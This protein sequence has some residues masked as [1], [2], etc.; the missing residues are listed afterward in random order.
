MKRD[1]YN[2]LCAWKQSSS[3]KPLILK[4]ARQVGKTY[5]LQEFGAKEYDSVAYYNFEEDPDLKDIFT[6]RMSP[7]K[8]ID[9]L[10]IYQESRITPDNT[11]II[12][13]EVQN[14]PQT[15]T[16]LKYFCEN[17]PEY[18]IAAAGSLLGVKVGQTAPFP[19][20]KV[21]FLDMHPMAFGEFLDALGKEQLRKYIQEK[22]DFNSI[23]Q[24]FHAEL[25]DFLKIYYFVGG[26]P[27]AVGQ[28][29]Q[30]KDLNT[31]RKIQ[32]EILAAYEMDFSKYTTKAEAIR[33]SGIWASIPGQ[34]S[35]EN[36]KFILS[37]VDKNARAREY[38]ES[39]QWLMD[40]GLVKKAN[41]IKIPKLPLSGYLDDKFKIYLLD[42]GLLGAM[43]N[44]SQKAIIEGD[45]LFSEYNGA[46][47]ENYVAQEFAAQGEKELY[48]WASRHTAEIDFIAAVKDE[49]L[50]LEVKSGTSRQKKSL[51]VYGEKF[52]PP[53]LSRST[54]MNFK[55][56]GK[57]RNY[58]LYA[59]SLFLKKAMV[60]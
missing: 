59:V 2:Q 3:R 22:T 48:Y 21:N 40:A 33:I 50:P 32:K 30:D 16:S 45:R 41:N 19:V 14:S 25:I 23:P 58:P 44:V 47:V 60:A 24:T 28:Y 5:I 31:V 57:I 17:A 43:I 27:E 34:L 20:G 38:N 49:I 8:I 52:K 35:R 39:I 1:I 7:D 46:F 6:G 10:S 56:D 15:L 18:H 42:V 53:V 9:Q 4:G 13:D 26:M 11:L 55:E 36:K 54:L 29:V 37:Q 51:I 12:F